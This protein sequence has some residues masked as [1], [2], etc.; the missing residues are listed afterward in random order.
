[1]ALGSLLAVCSS[2]QGM[3]YQCSTE[4]RMI[5][6]WPPTAMS[7]GPPDSGYLKAACVRDCRCVRNPNPDAPPTIPE[8]RRRAQR[9]AVRI[10]PSGGNPSTSGTT[11]ASSDG[12]SSVGDEDEYECLEFYGHPVP[13]DCDEAL[14]EIKS[15]PD[16]DL[17]REF[18]RPGGRPDPSRNMGR[19]HSSEPMSTPKSFTHGKSSRHSFWISC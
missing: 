14:D 16:Q 19:P 17:L 18:I 12:E 8:T 2:A 11:S 5:S 6:S 3:G 7:I 1:M 10:G 15:L 4:G 13:S 9:P